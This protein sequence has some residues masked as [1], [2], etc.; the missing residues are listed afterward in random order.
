MTC[1]PTFALVVDPLEHDWTVKTGTG[2]F[3]LLGYPSATYICF[4]SGK[5][6]IPAPLEIVLAISLVLPLIAVAIVY[7]L[8]RRY[9]LHNKAAT[10]IDP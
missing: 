5:I 6:E 8:R 2:S 9:I 3:G 1:L 4:G 7:D 10:S